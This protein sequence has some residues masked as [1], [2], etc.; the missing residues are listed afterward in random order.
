MQKKNEIKLEEEKQLLYYPHS[1]E[2]HAIESKVFYHL[3][4]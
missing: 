3:T 2:L 4:F 1:H